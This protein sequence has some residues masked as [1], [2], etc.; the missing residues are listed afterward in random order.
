MK[1]KKEGKRE[2]I[3]KTASHL[4]QCQGYHGTGLNQIIEE[5]GA[6]K[7]SLYYHFPKGKEEIALEAILLMKQQVLEEAQK[8]LDAKD[9][10]VEAFQFHIEKIAADFDK[11]EDMEGL[12]IG[13]IASETALTNE[14]I[15]CACQSAFQEWQFFYVD[16][17]QQFGYPKER[18]EELSVAINAMIE[19]GC[20]L[21]LTSESGDPLRMI[22]KQLPLLLK[23]EE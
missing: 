14:K 2:L 11:K 22:A 4:F 3:I 20:I 10:A 19:G 13:L 12:P 7:G 23:R 6:P 16:K 15:R 21:S 8:D 9:S 17:L 5:S 1:Y 18:A